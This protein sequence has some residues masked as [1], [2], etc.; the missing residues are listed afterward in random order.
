MIEETL[1][2]MLNFLALFN[3]HHTDFSHFLDQLRQIAHNVHQRSFLLRYTLQAFVVADFATRGLSSP[4]VAGNGCNFRVITV[5]A[6]RGE[7]SPLVDFW[8]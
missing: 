6:T 8:L 1:E 3:H 5:S 7:Y 2:D 4:L